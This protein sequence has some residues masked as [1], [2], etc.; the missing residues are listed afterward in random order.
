MGG[1]F[2]LGTD[3][4]C[5]PQFASVRGVSWDG[6]VGNLTKDSRS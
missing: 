2:G 4:S 3:W 6:S 1:S 5:G